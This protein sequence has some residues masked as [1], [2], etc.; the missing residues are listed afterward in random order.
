VLIMTASVLFASGCDQDRE[1]P[2]ACSP[3]D[4]RYPV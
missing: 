4:D 2:R 3:D 1:K